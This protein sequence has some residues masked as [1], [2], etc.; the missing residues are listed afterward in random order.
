M[1]LAFS[2]LVTVNCSLSSL[3]DED[4]KPC[5]GCDEC[6]HLTIV[7]NSAFSSSDLRVLLSRSYSSAMAVAEEEEAA[8][9]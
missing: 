8:E 4:A 7:L 1:Q 2:L 6:F 5:I 3:L 9:A